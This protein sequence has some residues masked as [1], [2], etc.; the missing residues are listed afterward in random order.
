MR[1][2]RPGAIVLLHDGCGENSSQDRSR[3]VEAA[4]LVI[5]GLKS[6]GYGFLKL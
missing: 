1:R 6:L 4:A 5:R 3:S 2:T